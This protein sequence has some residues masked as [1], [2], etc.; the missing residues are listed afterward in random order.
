M[1]VIKTKKEN[2]QEFPWNSLVLYTK[3]FSNLVN[4]LVEC[5]PCDGTHP[6]GMTL[7]TKLSKTK[8]MQWNKIRFFFD[9][10]VVTRL[11]LTHSILDWSW[12]LT[13]LTHAA[14]E[15]YSGISLTSLCWNLTRLWR[16]TRSAS[17]WSCCSCVLV[18]MAWTLQAMLVK[19]WVRCGWWWGA[20]GQSL[21]SGHPPVI[22][23]SCLTWASPHTFLILIGWTLQAV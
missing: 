16:W 23:P 9:S 14:G 2:I 13:Q 1:T 18:P 8:K 17:E 11:S 4:G 10:L 15:S 3:Y 19:C 21:H 20:P 7:S 12:S 6:L 5:V 22:G